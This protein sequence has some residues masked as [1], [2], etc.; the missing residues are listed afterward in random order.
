[1]TTF[2]M[3]SRMQHL[4]IGIHTNRG[5][6]GSVQL[7]NNSLVW[8]ETTTIRQQFVN[9]VDSVVKWCQVKWVVQNCWER[10]VTSCQVEISSV[11]VF[12]NVEKW[13]QKSHE[14]LDC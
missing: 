12:I 2:Q 5:N 8:C 9:N 7:Q 13:K 14:K 3:I 11:E 1:M 6:F 4:I 10:Q